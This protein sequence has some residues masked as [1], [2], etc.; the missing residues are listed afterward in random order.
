MS[1]RRKM[2]RVV[3]VLIFA[4]VS[5]AGI[6]C[7]S[8]KKQK[9]EKGTDYKKFSE[10]YKS[11]KKI[12]PH[13]AVELDKLVEKEPDNLDAAAKWLIYNSTNWFKNAKIKK[14]R[15]K[16]IF[17]L[18]E[19]HPECEI[20]G[21]GF[22]NLYK[23]LNNTDKAVKLWKLQLKKQ[24]ENTKILSN[25][26]RNSLFFDRKL[27]EKCLKKAQELEPDNP[28]WSIRL[29]NL[30]KY[31]SFKDKKEYIKSYN[32]YK[33]AYKQ[34][35]IEK[36]SSVLI[37]LGQIAYILGKYKEA[38]KYADEMLVYGGKYSKGA[39]LYNANTL[40][41][42]LALKDG[43][44]EEACKYLVKSGEIIVSKKLPDFY[45]DMSLACMLAYKKQDK[46]VLKYLETIAK[47]SSRNN[48]KAY[49]KDLKAGVMPEYRSIY[50]YGLS[51]DKIYTARRKKFLSIGKTLSA[52]QAAVLEKELA[53]LPVKNTNKAYGTITK[54]VAYYYVNK[55]KDKSIPEKRRQLIYRLVEYFPRY[56]LLAYPET[57]LRGKKDEKL[58]VLCKASIKKFKAGDACPL[59]KA[60]YQVATH[61]NKLAEEA[62]LKSFK[63]KPDDSKWKKALARFYARVKAEKPYMK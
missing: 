4:A 19:N 29:G 14:K 42:M 59:H 53:K 26:A 37:S 58:I 12:T 51:M 62:F 34:I 22:A 1:I 31:N 55:D 40:L 48:C 3:F 44:T 15:E 60:A 33:R 63:V 46:C 38:G 47:Y 24:P 57:W 21:W 45:A 41:G 30:Y 18:I 49:I 6:Q 17:H 27:C 36:R 43:K 9:A 20:F 2:N 52:K 10:L 56:S 61:D 5:L 54:L 39:C 28:D 16:I 23:R 25:A 8:V 7:T 35:A 32:E 13:E 50:K 11:A